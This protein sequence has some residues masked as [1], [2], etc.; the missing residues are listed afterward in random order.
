V[1]STG[2]DVKALKQA[3]LKAIEEDSEF[4]YAI[5]GAIGLG[6]VL[7][8]LRRLREDFSKRFEALERKMIEHDKRFEEM[9]R[10]FEAL[11]RKMIEYDKRFETLERKLLEHDKRFEAIEKKLLEHDKRFESIERKLLEHDKRFET[12]EKKLL[13]HDK[14]F[15]II[16]KQL[17]EHGSAIKELVSAVTKLASQITSLGNRYGVFTDEALRDAMKYVVEDLLKS[18]RVERWIYYDSNGVVYGRPSVVEVDLVIRDGEHVLVEFKASADRGDVAELY[19]IGQ[20]YERVKGVKPRLVLV[21]P[22]IRRRARELAKE[23]GVELRGVVS[24]V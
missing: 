5:A 13:E 1:G 6:E 12:I 7:E 17:L 9:N 19:R 11:E 2:I 20:L 24:E 14:R 21:S 8:E 15:E 16:E 3:F 22:A 4:R 23:L 10:R 18:G